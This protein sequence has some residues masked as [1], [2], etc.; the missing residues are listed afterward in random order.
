[1]FGLLVTQV[2]PASAAAP[3]VNASRLLLKNNPL[4]VGFGYG[5]QLIAEVGG[6]FAQSY[7]SPLVGQ[8]VGMS[9]DTL[10]IGLLGGQQVIDN[11]CKLVCGCS[12]RRGSA[13]PPPHSSIELPPV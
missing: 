6:L 13:E 2:E 5:C 1:T 12:Y 7:F 4:C 10:G 9:Q 11:A 8:M 3:W